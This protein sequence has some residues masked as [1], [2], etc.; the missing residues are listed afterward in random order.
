MKIGI[1]GGTF[2]PWTISHHEIVHRIMSR[3]LVDKMVIMPTIVNWHRSSKKPWLDECQRRRAILAAFGDKAE[4][5]GFNPHAGSH[6]HGGEWKPVHKG[7]IDSCSTDVIVDF[8][9]YAVA[10]S[11]L[12]LVEN[13]RY[14]N[15]LSDAIY[16]Y[17]EANEYFTVIGGDSYKNLPT[18]S[19]HKAV[20]AMSK[21]IVVDGRDGEVLESNL[22]HDANV[23]AV[24]TLGKEFNGVSATKIREQYGRDKD[25]LE[26]YIESLK[27]LV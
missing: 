7:D 20:T 4:E 27:N 19:R 5:V 9:E 24:V 18:W 10:Y 22:V 1:F 6:E 14:V 17:G 15:M 13:R 2:D 25:G 8:S 23:A 26:K 3:R 11:D 21:L 16:R 12:F